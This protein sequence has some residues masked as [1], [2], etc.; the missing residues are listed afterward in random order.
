MMGPRGASNRY[1]FNRRP[2]ER[3]CGQIWHGVVKQEDSYSYVISTGTRKHELP[4][5]QTAIWSYIGILNNLLGLM[6]LDYLTIQQSK[7]VLRSCS[8]YLSVNFS[9]YEKLPEFWEMN[10]RT[11]G[12]PMSKY[13]STQR[14]IA[15]RTICNTF[16]DYWIVKKKYSLSSSHQSKNCQLI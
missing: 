12:L 10:P 3:C 15:I 7:K 2:A 8:R 16:F 9:Y 14:K 13:A 11:F 4:T 1:I 6:V 5:L